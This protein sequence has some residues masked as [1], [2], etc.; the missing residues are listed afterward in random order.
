MPGTVIA[1]VLTKLQAMDT[2]YR[3]RDDGTESSLFSIRPII[4]QREII[5]APRTIPIRTPNNTSVTNTNGLNT[6]TKQALNELQ[7]QT[8]HTIK[9]PQLMYSPMQG[10]LQSINN[11]HV[12]PEYDHTYLSK[13]MISSPPILLHSVSEFY[14]PNS[15]SKQWNAI[16]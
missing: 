4:V 1:D 11:T 7:F 13:Y 12:Q 14:S 3:V 10:H 6:V 9:S 16:A 15:Q 8:A 5:T 2:V